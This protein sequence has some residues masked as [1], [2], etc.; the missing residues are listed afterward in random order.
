MV[1]NPQQHLDITLTPFVTQGHSLVKAWSARSAH[2]LQL[3]TSS[4]WADVCCLCGPWVQERSTSRWNQGGSCQWLLLGQLLVLWS[5]GT[6][7]RQE[8]LWGVVGNED[9]DLQVSEKGTGG[10][11]GQSQGLTLEGN[12]GRCCRGSSKEKNGKWHS[13]ACKEGEGEQVCVF[14]KEKDA[15]HQRDGHRFYER[16]KAVEEEELFIISDAFKNVFCFQ[17]QNFS[18]RKPC[19]LSFT[20]C[21]PHPVHPD[22][23]PKTLHPFFWRMMMTRTWQALLERPKLWEPSSGFAPKANLCNDL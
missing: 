23:V 14:V 3:Q 12:A 16:C 15:P 6:G 21:P 10:G 20:P 2:C 9:C 4:W 7:H 18:V 19:Q 5:R 17:T 22:P 1:L 11:A 8:L 13:R